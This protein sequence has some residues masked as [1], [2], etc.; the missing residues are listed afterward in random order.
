MSDLID[1]LITESTDFF[2]R[3]KVWGEGR[4]RKGMVVGS[5]QSGKTASMLGVIGKCLEKGTKIVVLLSGTKTSL[6]H[7]TLLRFYDE[8]DNIADMRLKS[9]LRCILPR[10]YI[11]NTAHNVNL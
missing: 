9:K 1:G 7:Q 2:E 5:I 3:K 4:L 8:L 11:V 6:W 10:R